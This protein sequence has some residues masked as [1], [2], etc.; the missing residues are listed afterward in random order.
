[1]VNNYNLTSTF[2]GYRMMKKRINGKLV[3]I[4]KAPAIRLTK[5]LFRFLEKCKV[6]TDLQYSIVQAQ[7][8]TCNEKTNPA[9]IARLCAILEKPVAGKLEDK[10]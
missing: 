6:I 10:K 3:S 4:P 5:D 2:C 7:L 1:M 9:Y 8:N